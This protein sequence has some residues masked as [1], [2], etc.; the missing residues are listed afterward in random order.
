VLCLLHDG[1]KLFVGYSDAQ[2]RVWKDGQVIGMF[3]CLL[4]MKYGSK[5]TRL[6]FF[7]SSST[8]AHYRNIKDLLK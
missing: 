8:Q 6:L 3:F 7:F 1:E 4:Y 5:I 2:V